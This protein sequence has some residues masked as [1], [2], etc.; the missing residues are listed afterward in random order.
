MQGLG[1]RVFL[2]SGLRSDV[3]AG[4]ADSPRLDWA[5]LLLRALLPRLCDFLGLLAVPDVLSTC[6]STRYSRMATT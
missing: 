5:G 3:G 1:F 2:R 6:A 4:A